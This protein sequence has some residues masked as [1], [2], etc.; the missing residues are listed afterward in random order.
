MYQKQKNRG[1]CYFDHE[2]RIRFLPDCVV[3]RILIFCFVRQ[4]IVQYDLLIQG[5]HLSKSEDYQ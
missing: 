3:S 5:Q 4:D 2:K 1:K